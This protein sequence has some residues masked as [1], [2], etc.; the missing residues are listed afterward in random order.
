MQLNRIFVVGEEANADLKSVEI[1]SNQKLHSKSHCVLGIE[2]AKIDDERRE[3]S[4]VYEGFMMY[5]DEALIPRKEF[6]VRTRLVV[7][8]TNVNVGDEKRKKL[9]LPRL[10]LLFPISKI[11]LVK[12]HFPLFAEFGPKK[13]ILNSVFPT[14]ISLD[15]DD[16]DNIFC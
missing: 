14:E 2:F 1:L 7:T 3:E 12:L 11:F 16:D 13:M 8:G 9:P 6:L 5:I 4:A 10:L 15:D